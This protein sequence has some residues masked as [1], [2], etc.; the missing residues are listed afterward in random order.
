MLDVTTLSSATT[1]PVLP[2]QGRCQWGQDASW[3]PLLQ[4]GFGNTR[5]LVRKYSSVYVCVCLRWSGR[6]VPVFTN[7]ALFMNHVCVR[8]FVSRVGEQL[9]LVFTAGYCVAGF[10]GLA[11]PPLLASRRG[12][13]QNPHCRPACVAR[14][15]YSACHPCSD[16]CTPLS[17][18]HQRAARKRPSNKV[19]VQSHKHASSLH[20]SLARRGRGHPVA[21]HCATGPPAAH[22][23]SSHSACL[24]HTLN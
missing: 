2:Q 9:T 21:G 20:P 16:P 18:H 8:L 3:A 15:P 5:L 7:S 22:H 10:A 6:L 14:E 17:S 23:S 24:S 11:R 13:P 4:Y 19:H 1:C 12:A